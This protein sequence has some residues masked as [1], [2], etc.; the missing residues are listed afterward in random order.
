MQ[1]VARGGD[2][3]PREGPRGERVTAAT[4]EWPPPTP[5]AQHARPRGAHDSR[6][7]VVPTH[8]PVTRL[9]AYE[10]ITR[11]RVTVH[12][13]VAREHARER[14]GQSGRRRSGVDACKQQNTTS[15]TNCLYENKDELTRGSETRT[16]V[17]LHAPHVLH[18]QNSAG[19]E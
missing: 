1:A 18:R 12:E 2:E 4:A 11:V 6:P 16:V 3:G 19:G 5:S 14:I 10:H 13:P 8:R 17:N 7:E 9:P 15:Y